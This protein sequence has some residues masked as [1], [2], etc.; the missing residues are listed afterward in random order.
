MLYIK[1][2]YHTDTDIVVL[3]LIHKLFYHL[4]VS[5]TVNAFCSFNQQHIYTP[6]MT[7]FIA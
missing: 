6:L 3:K 2:L 1:N 5:Y 7:S 4:R